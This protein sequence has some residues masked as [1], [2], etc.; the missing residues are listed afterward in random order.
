MKKK[1]GYAFVNRLYPCKCKKLLI[2]RVNNSKILYITVRIG[3]RRDHR[4]F[5]K[6]KKKRQKEQV[7]PVKIFKK[8]V[9]WTLYDQN[10]RNSNLPL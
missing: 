8:K 3:S 2:L 6:I 1:S 9:L 4:T 5:K 7:V 10:T